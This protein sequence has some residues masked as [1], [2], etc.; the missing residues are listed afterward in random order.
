MHRVS[1]YGLAYYRRK[2]VSLQTAEQRGKIKPRVMND[3]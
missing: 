1:K 3:G 2:K